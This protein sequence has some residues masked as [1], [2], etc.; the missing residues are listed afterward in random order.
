MDLS[1]IIVTHNS[2][3]PVERCLSSLGK[4][5]PSCASETIVIDNASRDGTPEMISSRFPLTRL[6]ANPGNAGYSR[7]VNQGI[8][9]SSSDLILILNPDIEVLEG[10]IDRLA[11]FMKAHPRCGMAGSKLVYQ[12][13]TLQYSCRSFYTLPA[14]LLRRTF[15]GRLFPRARALRKHLLADYDHEE[16]REVDWLIGACMMARRDAVRKVGKMD[17]RFFLYFEDTD[18]CYRMHHHGWQV[19]YVPSSVMIHSYERSSAKSVFRRPFLLHLLSLMR[20]FEKWNRLFHFLRRYRGALKS[21]V[22]VVSDLAAVNAGFFAAYGLRGALQPFFT[23]SLYP[24]DWYAYFIIFYNV[25][26]FMTFLFTGLYSIRRETGAVLE[27]TRIVRSVMIVF[28]ILLGATYL[29]RIRIYSRAVLLGQAFFTVWAVFVIRRIIRALHAQLVRASFDLKRVVLAGREDEIR[30]FGAL[31]AADPGLGIDIVGYVGPG[32]DSLGDPADLGSLLERFM[33]Q[34]IIIMPSCVEDGSVAALLRDSAPR[35]TSV[36]IVSPVARF[37]GGGVRVEKI[38]RFHMFSVE[39]GAQYHLV[40][41]AMRLT[42][43]LAGAAALPLCAAA[44]AVRR[45]RGRASGGVSFFSEK[46]IGRGGTVISWPRAV[47]NGNKEMSDIFKPALCLMLIDGRLGLA[48]PPAMLPE[49]RF[50]AGGKAV[51]RPGVSGLWR[52]NPRDAM[53]TAFEDEIID[54]RGRTFA[55]YLEI[56]FRSLRLFIS[57]EYPGWFFNNWRKP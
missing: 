11:G 5:P 7:G 19:W 10:S 35:Q 51:P 23:N 39:R 14:L 45:A 55:G 52:L 13:G 22:F 57:G 32:P 29:T 40:R 3:I 36:R 42:D 21:F 47:G 1:I 6:V 34:E 8:A 17:E 54:S 38:G 4:N 43:I 53:E 37:I 18:W 46:R 31:A 28:A 26:F 48:G 2:R 44:A 56:V 16:A 24:L 33:I 12:D 27:F 49:W 30:E 25:I 15:L 9:L 50:E 20:Y 41:A